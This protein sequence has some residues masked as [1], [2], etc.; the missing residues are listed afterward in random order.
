MLRIHGHV[1]PFWT[2]WDHPISHTSCPDV[3]FQ[4]TRS[5]FRISESVFTLDQ[6]FCSWSGLCLWYTRQVGLSRFLVHFQIFTS[7]KGSAFL[8]FSK[9]SR[10]VSLVFSHCKTKYLTALTDRQGGNT[11]L[12]RVVYRDG[13][14]DILVTQVMAN[15]YYQESFTTCISLVRFAAESKDIGWYGSISVIDHQ[16]CRCAHCTGE[17]PP[18]LDIINTKHN[19]TT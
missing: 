7:Q 14:S 19:P 10:I 11:A 12:F 16:R 4:P 3:I 15:I 13:K 17:F 18:E 6:I 1:S 5:N 9:V 8:W 2:T